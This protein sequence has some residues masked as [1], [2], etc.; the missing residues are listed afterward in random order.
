MNAPAE[1][2]A[3]VQ[4]DS[5]ALQGHRVCHGADDVA[6]HRYLGVPYAAPPVGEL[7][8]QAPQPAMPWQ[9][10]RLAD[11]QGDNAPQR[12][13]PFDAAPVRGGFSEDCLTL[14][15]WAPAEPALKPRAVMVWI[16]GGGFV[17][18]GSSPARYDGAGLA[19]RGVLVV[20][21]NYR[22]GRLGF[23]AHPALRRAQGDD[24]V[25]NFGLMD[26]LAALRWVRRNIAAFG[27]DPERVTVF[28][29]SAGGHSVAWLMASPAARGLFAQ[30]ILQ[31]APLRDA[32]PLGRRTLGLDEAGVRAQKWARSVGVPDGEGATVR[33][34]LHALPVDVLTAGLG[35]MNP[36]PDFH[37][38]VRG[39]SVW[40]ASP[41]QAAMRGH[42]PRMPVLVGSN[43]DEMGFL[44]LPHLAPHPSAERALAAFG[45]GAAAI[46]TAYAAELRQGAARFVASLRG[47]QVFV[48]PSRFL[49]RA[50]AP[51]QPV[52]AYRFAHG[53]AHAAGALHATE[54]PFVFDTLDTLA[55]AGAG[56]GAGEMAL[57]VRMA[58]A[59]A[60]FAQTGTP[61]DWPRWQAGEEP[62]V[63]LDTHGAVAGADPARARLDAVAFAAASLSGAS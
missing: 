13:E 27:G 29:E 46:E 50:L 40:P 8:W 58:G 25:G 17:S 23:F 1:L 28:G 57:A 43:S 41:E 56:A 14:N 52:F 39:G 61:G 21:L 19:S 38:P 10:V 48:E 30:A 44:A 54:L 47:D 36:A 9:G 16:H 15:V 12:P 63:W 26:Q 51:H 59:W 18:G 34:A 62:L 42:L 4:T 55:G 45:D 49:A 60:S 3:V 33:A 32:D 5:G 53:G 37:G 35:L 6:L 24:A 20:S 2:G 11:R 7:R 31:S 22:L